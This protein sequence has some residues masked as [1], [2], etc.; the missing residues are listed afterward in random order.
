MGDNVAIVRIK[1]K[2]GRKKPPFNLS[3]LR[4][5]FYTKV[6][7][8]FHGD[9]SSKVPEGKGQAGVSMTGGGTGSVRET[10]AF[11]TVIDL[12]VQEPWAALVVVVALGPGN[13]IL[14]TALCFSVIVWALDPFWTGASL[15]SQYLWS[16][17]SRWCWQQWLAPSEVTWTLQNF[18]ISSAQLGL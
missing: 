17:Y 8:G 6:V 16:D 2:L 13:F 5:I 12:A 10:G 14:G 4:D 9:E 11:L 3:W 18:A 1:G 15:W 7:S